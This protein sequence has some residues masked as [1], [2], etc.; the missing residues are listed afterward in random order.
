MM[1]LETLHVTE[2]NIR[3]AKLDR[4]RA[5]RNGA[6]VGALKLKKK[7]GDLEVRSEEVVTRL[8]ERLK[9]AWED[10]DEEERCPNP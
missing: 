6:R 7:W 9:H 8:V 5:R 10:W 2:E 1:S 4:L 3:V